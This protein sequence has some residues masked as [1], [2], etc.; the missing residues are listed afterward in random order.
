MAMTAK[1][2]R[3]GAAAAAALALSLT[4]LALAAG[5]AG[6]QQAHGFAIDRFDPSERGSDWFTLESLDL[7]GHARP[8]IGILGDFG[9]RP[10]VLYNP[11]GSVGASVVRNQFVL[12]P[13]GNVVLWDR[14]RVGFNF[15]IAIFQ[16][17]HGATINGVGFAPPSGP[18]VGDLRLGA[19]LRLVGEYTD[20]LTLAVG[21]QVYLP[22]GSRTDY[23]GDGSARL[24]PRLLA[25]GRVG[26]LVYA[27][28]VAFDYRSLDDTLAG[29]QLGSEMLFGAS[30]GVKLLEDRIVLGPE[31]FGSTVVTGT[32]GPFSARNTP[33]ELLLGGH[34][35]VADDFRFGAGFGPGITRG[36]GAPALRVLLSIEW[37]PGYDLPPPPDRDRDGVPDREDACP[38]TPGIRT[39]D[40]KTNGCPPAPPSDRDHDGIL[41]SED[42]CPDVPG[43]RTG[44]PKTNGCPP[45]PSD[46]DNDGIF[47]AD[48]ACPEE[49]GPKT[50]DP[51]TNGCPD[52]DKDGV[53]DKVDACPDVPGVATADPKTNGCPG[54]RDNDGILDN[55]DACP[56]N[57]GPRNADPKKNGCPMAVVQAGQIRI[58]EQVKFRLGKADL[59]PASDPILEAVRKVIADH[60]EIRRVRVEGHTDNIGSAAYNLNLSKAR[61]GSVVRWL[62]AHGVDAGRLESQ[63]YGLM[64]PIADNA[65]EEGRRDNRRVE[66][67][68]V[69]SEKGELEK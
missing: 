15:P 12:H 7:R 67:H 24:Q 54:D 50:A 28:K 47:D 6:A 8:A 37:A 58:M 68:I 26:P 61:A 51:R 52:R 32:D 33:F 60:A 36:M 64:R 25:A 34:A 3:R 59:D 44:D 23:T 57:P 9:Y 4:A 29:T 35:R 62:I 16:D 21:L 1:P 40:T 63:G 65:T 10:L 55:E 31:L 43:V 11:D 48:D 2:A 18:N 42:A 17:G 30:A 22:T 46:R 13:G 53:P 27:A 66:L 5:S 56:D 45:V 39:N 14:L 49:A 20:P 38:D 41:D 19:D 69:D